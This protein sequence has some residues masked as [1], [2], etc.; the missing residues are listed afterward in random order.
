MDINLKKP[1]LITFV[2]KTGLHVLQYQLG[3]ELYVNTVM[4]H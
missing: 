1:M 4:P 3:D 2:N